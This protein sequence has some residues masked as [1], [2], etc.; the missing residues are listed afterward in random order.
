MN[1]SPDKRR[2]Q[3]IYADD[4]QHSQHGRN[5]E[6]RTDRFPLR[7]SD[8]EWRY[9]RQHRAEIRHQIQYSRNA[10]REE[11]I[12][13]VYQKEKRPARKYQDQRHQGI[14]RDK[15]PKHGTDLIERLLNALLMRIGK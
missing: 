7:H 15:T 10:T 4:M 3:D 9:P 8:Q 1:S 5:P 11:G 13:Q 6:V 14:A 2:H 12:V